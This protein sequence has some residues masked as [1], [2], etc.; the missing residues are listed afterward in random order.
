MDKNLSYLTAAVGLQETGNGS[1][2]PDY[3]AVGDNGTAAGAYQWSNDVKGEPQALQPGQIPA[4]FKSDAQTYGLDPTDFSP[5]NQDKVALA[6]MSDLYK[7]YGASGAVAAWNA[8]EGMAENGKWK[9]N[10]GTTTI[11]GKTI[12]YNTPKYVAGVSDLYKKISGSNGNYNPTPFSSGDVVLNTEGGTTNQKQ[13]GIVQSLVQGAVSPFLQGISSLNAFGDELSGNNAGADD[14]NTN[15]QDYG[16]LGNAKPVGAGFDITKPFSQNV[17]PLLSAVGTG[18]Q[19]GSEIAGGQG[20]LSSISSKLVGTGATSILTNPALEDALGG[21][22]LEDFNALGPSD[23]LDTITNILKNPD[24]GESDKLVLQKAYDEV[25]PQAQAQLGVSE[26]Q[27]WAQTHPLISKAG[28]L[29]GKVATVG[30]LFGLGSELP[31]LVSAISNLT[32]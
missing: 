28:G 31:G 32:K 19:A 21:M 26:P 7:K 5:K 20:L 8:G 17:K 25:L 27:T 12:S 9:S 24:I 6:K 23:Q 22:P 2:N 14:L 1:M 3:S 13:P 15:G 18:A 10:V 11:N 16:Y 29:L 4:N 30:G